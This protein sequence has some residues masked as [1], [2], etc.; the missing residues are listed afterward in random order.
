MNRETA[1]EIIK[2]QI[3]C[4]ILLEKSK[5]GLYICPFCGS[6]TGKN[7][8][9][10]LQYYKDTN[11]FYCHACNK[12]GDCIDLYMQQYNKDY[13]AALYEMA[14]QIGETIDAYSPQGATEGAQ[15]AFK[16]K[17]NINIPLR[18]KAA[19]IDAER[20]A[21]DNTKY[22]LECRNRITE[23]Q[24]AEYLKKRGITTETAAAYWLGYDAAADPA[25]SGHPTPRIII[26]T[27]EAH[28]IGRRIDGKKEFAKI[29]NKGAKPA[30][31][32]SEALEKDIKQ[33][34]V[35]EGAF[36]AL[37]VIQA[38]F[39]A[40]ALN[41]TSN[42][43]LLLEKL[44]EQPTSATLIL[45]PDNDADPKTRERVQ[46]KFKEL[47]D[48]LQRL[49]IKHIIADINCGYKDANEALTGN[50][51]KFIETLERIKI[52][53]A[54]K[55]DNTLYYLSALMP[56]EIERFKSDKKTGFYNLDSEA[57]GL[58]SGLYV[59]A[60]IS[61]LGKTSFALQLADQLAAGGQ[62]VLFFSLEQSRLELVSKS[63][64]RYTAK[65]KDGQPDTSKAITSLA[66]RKGN[67]SP[68]LTEAIKDYKRAIS[69][70]LSI[71]EGN[72]NCDIDFISD[73]IRRYMQQNNNSPIVFIDYLQILQPPAADRRAGTK[74]IID[75]NITALKRI[76][77]EL[78]L[79]VI[80]IS[81]VNRA[82]YLTPIDFESLKESGGIEYSCDVLWG[83][84]LACLSDN[85]I[86]T[87]SNA[88]MQDKRDI[89]KKAKAANPR[90]IELSCLKNR[91]GIANYSCRFNYYPANDLFVEVITDGNPFLNK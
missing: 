67:K 83:L 80:V 7:S 44:E 54:P 68:Q 50:Y 17:S 16:A 20:V 9:G 38:G 39:P 49:N 72:F 33:L 77:R 51:K 23:P 64:A 24:A 71:V 34:F 63:L 10:A 70:R 27:S 28:Y 25:Q 89:V 61:S 37:S 74:E 29:N 19:K 58:Y 36:D 15:K 48:G 88:T 13:N 79:T 26:P 11:T 4:E 56:A 1:K 60:A 42:A 3:S 75:G 78:D 45:C 2:E 30:I 46:Q 85:D 14:E 91:Y 81:S 18:E 62:D 55:P 5:S 82:N 52:E 65:V 69:D 86:F 57:G 31:F 59:L 47:A 22:Y 32:N 76:S 8:T 87:K 53:L 84:Q 90:Q 12:S 41:S 6:G 73:Y 43:K 66:I 21:E 40:I 35:L